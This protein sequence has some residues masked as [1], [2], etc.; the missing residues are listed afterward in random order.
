MD[1]KEL[2]KRW[3]LAYTEPS[4]FYIPWKE[5]CSYG[6][7]ITV[8]FD[9]P[10]YIFEN[11]QRRAVFAVYSN[12]NDEKKLIY[13]TAIYDDNN[14]MVSNGLYTTQNQGIAENTMFK[15]LTAHGSRGGTAILPSGNYKI[16][17]LCSGS[18]IITNNIY[19]WDFSIEKG[20]S[21]NPIRKYGDMEYSWKDVIINPFKGYK[22]LKIDMAVELVKQSVASELCSEDVFETTTIDDCRHLGHYVED[23]SQHSGYRYDQYYNLPCRY[24]DY[25][26]DKQQTSLYLF[27]AVFNEI[28]N[29][30]KNNTS[31]AMSR[32]TKKIITAPEFYEDGGNNFLIFNNYNTVS[33]KKHRDNDNSV[34]YSV[35]LGDI[36][37]M[38]S[39]EFQYSD[40]YPSYNNKVNMSLTSGTILEETIRDTDNVCCSTSANSYDDDDK[41]I[42][43][44]LYTKT[45]ELSNRFSPIVEDFYPSEYYKSFKDRY[46]VHVNNELQIAESI[47]LQF[48]AF[49]GNSENIVENN[50]GFKR[51]SIKL[52]NLLNNEDIGWYRSKDFFSIEY[53]YIPDGYSELDVKVT[54]SEEEFVPY[55]KII[56]TGIDWNGYE[57][58]LEEDKWDGTRLYSIDCEVY[59]PE[60][61]PKESTE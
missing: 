7:Q 44:V 26:Y 30:I 59:H 25:F 61:I 52:K 42:N 43:F 46:D 21:P 8:R 35:A 47:K 13:C 14:N 12:N 56:D 9:L 39:Y 48:N 37:P 55:Y 17:M 60:L 5:K 57:Y 45:K 49:I 11:W 51:I 4:L 15:V 34:D 41:I 32:G 1:R 28:K 40:I 36:L 20:D 27:K 38:W 16:K 6:E 24:L 18:G 22:C 54:T 58:Y 10:E 2:L 19:E 3:A 33:L 50:D 53:N 29:D 31:N 23:S